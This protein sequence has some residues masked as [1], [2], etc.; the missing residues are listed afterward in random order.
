MLSK[1]QACGELLREGES[2]QAKIR[3]TYHVLKSDI[4]FALDKNDM[5]YVKGSLKHTSCPAMEEL[6]D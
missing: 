4:V 1:C 5:E 3:S 2:V 6:N